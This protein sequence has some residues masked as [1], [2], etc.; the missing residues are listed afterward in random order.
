[1]VLR[2][3]PGTGVDLDLPFI[4]SVT[5]TTEIVAAR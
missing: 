5:L 2:T 3:G 1:V 4:D